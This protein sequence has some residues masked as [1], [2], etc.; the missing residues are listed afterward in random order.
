MC[1]MSYFLLGSQN[2][3]KQAFLQKKYLDKIGLMQI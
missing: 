2:V 1:S 3:C